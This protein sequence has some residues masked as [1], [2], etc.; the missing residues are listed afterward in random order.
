MQAGLEWFNHKSQRFPWFLTKLLPEK[1]HPPESTNYCKVIIFVCLIYKVQEM[2]LNMLVLKYPN[3]KFTVIFGKITPLN[4][5][6]KP[7]AAKAKA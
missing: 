7:P 3:T 1:T 2:C 4:D 5:P 6:P